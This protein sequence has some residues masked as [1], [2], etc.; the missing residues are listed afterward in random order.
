MDAG[1]AELAG[2]GCT[3]V[4]LEVATNNESAQ[5][6]YRRLGYQQSGRIPG[7]YPDGADALVMRKT[8]ADSAR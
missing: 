5:A 6:F 2:I 3:A 4:V 8:L 1:E 7:Y